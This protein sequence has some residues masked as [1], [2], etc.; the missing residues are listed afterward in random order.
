MPTIEDQLE[1]ERTM[2]RRGVETFERN[3]KKA[4]DKG[5]GAET[6][7]ARRLLH[8][9]M[10]PLIDQLKLFLSDTGPR[11]QGRIKPLLLACD[12]EKA[13]FMALQSLFNSFTHEA[14]LA[15]LATRIGRMVEDEVRFTRFQEM[16]GDYYDKIIADFKRKGTTDYRFK[17]R[18]LTHKANEHQ[19]QWVE[20]SITERA[21]IG[22]KLID[23]I[24]EHTD[25]IEKNQYHVKGKT[26]TTLVPTASAR[27]W[28]EQHNE[29]SKFLFPD[30]MPCVV[31]PDDWTGL[32]QGGY[33][34]PELRN[35]TPMVKYSSKRHKTVLLEADLSLL[36]KTLNILQRV[37]WQINS[38]VLQIMRACWANNL[39]IGMPQKDP[40]EIPPS[41]V[42]GKKG[43]TLTEAETEALTDWRHEAAEIHTQEKERI[44]KAFQVSRIIRLANEYE[45]H[46]AFYYVW[47][48]DFRG[49]LY[50]TT[51]GLSPQGSDL[52]KGL[53]RL[54]GGKPL[55]ERGWY[56]LQVH[57]ANRFGYDKVSYDDRVKWVEA[58]REHFLRAADDPMGNTDVW[59]NADK[60]WQFLA[61]LFEYRDAIALHSLG[62]P[63]ADYVSRLPIG[64]DGSCNGLQNFSAML[65]DEIGGT[66]T[67][68]VPADKPADIYTSVARVCTG[69]LRKAVTDVLVSQWTSFVDKY[70]N[71]FLPRDGAKR[72]V[73]TL[74][75]GATRQSCTKYIF[76]F[77]LKTDRKHFTGNFRAAVMLTPL[78][79]ASIGEVVV[80]AREAMG[81][82]QQASSVVT[83]DNA[84]LLWHAADGFPVYQGMR[85]IETKQIDTQLAGRF[86]LRVGTFTDEFDRNKQRSGVAPNFVHSKD[87]EHLRAVVR[88]CSEEGLAHIAMIHDDYGTYAADTDKLHDIIR[89]EFVKLYTDNNALQNFK[90]EHEARGHKLP[91]IPKMGTLDIA[92][93][94]N[95]LYFFG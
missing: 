54:S 36:M 42:E 74:P 32:E 19:D 14:P 12:P 75:Y 58:N 83:R 33:Y 93:V 44:S 67:N 68:L 57:G 38:D 18:V 62:Y 35:T 82:L 26:R 1:L 4:E 64:L 21:E 59:G 9:Y 63:I 80:A 65:R 37:P 69:K 60:P 92:Q 40:L 48:A 85:V 49:R 91:D 56:W 71:G 10:Q 17:H 70:G 41:P 78:L 11:R 25:L 55:G 47:Y 5:R 77:I 72:P 22:M 95:S 34:S 81:W 28:I 7:Y 15:G 53:L 89:D 31:Q 23:I 39:R 6:A 2:V 94:R 86:Q 30:K 29:F 84:P 90:D 76:D 13:M 46:N 66:A 16:H 24:L 3:Q 87:S 20:W 61:W 27:E 73:M 43:Q 79:W 45:H 8:E 50:P 51:A 52:A 88:R